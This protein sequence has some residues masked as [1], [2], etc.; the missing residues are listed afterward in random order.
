MKIVYFMKIAKKTM[1]EKATMRRRRILKGAIAKVSLAR[2]Y[3]YL[4]ATRDG[5]ISGSRH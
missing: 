2:A 5:T 3:G 1:L 4:W